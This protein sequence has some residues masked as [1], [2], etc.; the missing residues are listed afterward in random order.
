HIRGYDH[1]DHEEAEVM[2]ARERTLLEELVYPDP[3]ANDESADH[4]HSDTPSKD[5]E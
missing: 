3:Y 2:E 4:P 5:H 1:S